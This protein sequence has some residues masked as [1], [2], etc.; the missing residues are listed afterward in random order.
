MAWMLVWNRKCVVIVSAYHV[1]VNFQ[2]S[3]S[4]NFQKKF[5]HQES[6]SC[7]NFRKWDLGFKPSIV[8]SHKNSRLIQ[9][10]VGYFLLLN[11]SWKVGKEVLVYRVKKIQN[12]FTRSEHWQESRSNQGICDWKERFIWQ[13]S[14][15]SLFSTGK[16]QV[17][18]Q[19]R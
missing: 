12:T 5:G 19:E 3:D 2:L 15:K 9:T 4:G 1:G 17:S 11:L 13:L 7:C 18:P 14:E 8:W 6:L 16:K 10:D